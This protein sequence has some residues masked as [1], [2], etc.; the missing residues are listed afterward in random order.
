VPAATAEPAAAK[1]AASG[2]PKPE[3]KPVV[4][5]DAR[6]EPKAGKPAGGAWMVQVARVSSR[7]KAQELLRKLRGKGYQAVLSQQGDSWKVMVGPELSREVAT[8]TKNRL[9]ADGDIGVHDAWVQA[10]KP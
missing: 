5:V 8:S 4:K 6:P 9:N 3:P 2:V 10:Y 7:E 1:P